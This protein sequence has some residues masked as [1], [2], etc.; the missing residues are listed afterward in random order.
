MNGHARS[1]NEPLD[2]RDVD[3]YKGVEGRGKRP[4]DPGLAGRNGD[5]VAMLGVMMSQGEVMVIVVMTA[6]IV[7]IVAR[8]RNAKKK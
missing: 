4:G 7:F 2:F 3:W 6:V 5:S 1:L 8:K